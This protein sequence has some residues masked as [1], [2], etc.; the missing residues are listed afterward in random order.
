M[1]APQTYRPAQIWLHWVVVLGVIL[2]IALH[3]PIVRVVAARG[4]GRAADASDVTL[5]WVHVSVGSVILLAVIARLILRWRHG[6]PDHA[7]GMSEM[8]ARLA[9]GMHSA[10]YALLF[11]MVITGMLT[12]NEIAPLGRIH[13]AINIAL[14]FAALVH[15]AAAICNQI[16]RKDGTLARMTPRFRM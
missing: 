14:F 9:G 12:W 6:A 4:E 10:L 7:P 8:Q 2:Q 13:F 11:A 16:V 5:A 3:E 1:T 15:A